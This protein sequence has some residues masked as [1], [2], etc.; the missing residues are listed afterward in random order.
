MNKASIE[1]GIPMDDIE[2]TFRKVRMFLQKRLS[3]KMQGALGAAFEH[4]NEA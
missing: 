3:I 1:H 4:F 2:R